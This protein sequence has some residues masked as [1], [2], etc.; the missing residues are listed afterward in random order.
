MKSVAGSASLSAVLGIT[1]P[2]M[3]GL[4]LKYKR[5][6]AFAMISSAVAAAFMSFFHARALAYAPP[7]L[8][9]I[10]TYEADSF[11]F[12]IIASLIAFCLAAVLTFLFGIPAEAR[13]AAVAAGPD[14]AGASMDE[15]KAVSLPG[16]E[17][18]VTSP[19]KGKV[20]PLSEVPDGAF[21]GGE[22]GK[23]VGIEPA[24]GKVYAPFDGMVS[25]LPD[26]KHAIG[27]TSADGIEMLIHIG[28][29]TVELDGKFFTAHVKTGDAIQKGQ[30]LIEFDRKRIAEKYSMITP[31][32][33]TNFEEFGKVEGLSGMDAGTDT[34][35]LKLS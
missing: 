15:T 31:V 9:T 16:G 1:E 18:T 4:N 29:D 21:N 14:G 20:I 17:F 12:I 11:A 7:G 34:P 2:V 5:P 8:F 3:Y 24:E 26:T 25:M 19:I 28:L 23:G 22:M 13:K 27:L 6:F 33:V 32:L 10:V 30:L 35:I